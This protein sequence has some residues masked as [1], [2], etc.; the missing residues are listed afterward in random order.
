MSTSVHSKWGFGEYLFVFEK[1]SHLQATTYRGI[2]EVQN[3]AER[4]QKS[5]HCFFEVKTTVDIHEE[6][7]FSLSNEINWKLYQ[8]R[9]F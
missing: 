4:A 8:I 9:P 3:H 7:V 1:F 2:K 5:C 6:W